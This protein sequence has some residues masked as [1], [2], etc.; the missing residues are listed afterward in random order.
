MERAEVPTH[1]DTPS[2]FPLQQREPTH[3]DSTKEWRFKMPC[4]IELPDIEKHKSR[5]TQLPDDFQVQD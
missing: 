3:P 1:F 4:D 2:A 5:V